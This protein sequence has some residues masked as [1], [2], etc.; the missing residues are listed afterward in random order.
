MRLCGY[1][2][3][4]ERARGSMI[5]Y[6]RNMT[7]SPPAGRA[8][9][10]RRPRKIFFARLRR[11]SAPAAGRPT[12][13]KHP[14]PIFFFAPTARLRLRRAVT[15][16]L[17][18]ETRGLRLPTLD[19]GPPQISIVGMILRRA[20]R[21]RCVAALR[22]ARA[23]EGEAQ[24]ACCVGIPE[25]RAAS[26]PVDRPL[27]CG[28]RSVPRR[29]TRAMQTL[30]ELDA[31]LEAQRAAAAAP[32]QPPAAGPSSVA[33]PAVAEETVP[34]TVTVLRGKRSRRTPL[35]AFHGLLQ[36]RGAHAARRILTPIRRR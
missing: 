14:S 33:T 17:R 18:M 24:H 21:W 7:L 11:A 19:G 16:G 3:S 34:Q 29:A 9:G 13:E 23:R 4:C 5:S 15:D 22:V 36:A 6:T 28:R 2:A 30:A 25:T 27:A 1:Y 20:S 35:A 8:Y 12:D 26:L 31:A 10:W 32:Q